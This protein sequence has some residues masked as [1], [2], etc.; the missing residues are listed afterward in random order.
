[1]T[2]GTSKTS[3]SHLEMGINVREKNMIKTIRHTSRIQME[4]CVQGAYCHCWVLSPCISKKVFLVRI[5]QVFCRILWQQYWS[6][7]ILIK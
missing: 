3:I 7:S 2:N 4:P 5:Y 6:E 1:M